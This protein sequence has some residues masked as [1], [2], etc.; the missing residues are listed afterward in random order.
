MLLQP[1][2]P[3]PFKFALAIAPATG[4]WHQ[5]R[6]QGSNLTRLHSLHRSSGLL[7]R[8]S[9]N[10]RVLPIS[11]HRCFWSE[12]KL[13]NNAKSQ[14]SDILRQCHYHQG[15]TEASAGSADYKDEQQ[16]LSRRDLDL[17]KTVRSENFNL[18]S[19]IPPL[20]DSLLRTAGYYAM[21]CL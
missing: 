12:S 21:Q 5:S 1:Q 14:V 19:P 13:R 20:H 17:T 2:S 4:S 10:R 6:H 9:E 16:W 7:H 11:N 3:V 18:S 8:D 15:N